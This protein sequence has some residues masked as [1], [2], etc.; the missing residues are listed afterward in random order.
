MDDVSFY[1]LQIKLLYFILY[2][3]ATTGSFF[4]AIFK[5]INPAIKVRNMLINI[6]KTA[7]ATYKAKK[8]KAYKS[9][10][11]LWHHT[12]VYLIY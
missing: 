1:I 9:G 12:I 2:K 11:A 10:F 6:K 7:P 4:A 5:G 3:E 8:G